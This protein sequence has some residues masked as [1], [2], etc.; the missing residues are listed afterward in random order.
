MAGEQDDDPADGCGTAAGDEMD[1]WIDG[2]PLS[3]R[4]PPGSGGTGGPRPAAAV[5][6]QRRAAVPAVG[7]SVPPAPH[8]GQRRASS[9]AATPVAGCL[10]GG[11]DDELDIPL[12]VRLG[13]LRWSSGGMARHTAASGGWSTG[14]GGGGRGG[15]SWGGRSSRGG[16]ALDGTYPPAWTPAGNSGMGLA[17]TGMGDRGFGDEAPTQSDVLLSERLAAKA[18]S[19]RGLGAPRTSEQR[20]GPQGAPAAPEGRPRGN[21]WGEPQASEQRLGPEGMPAATGSG[22]WSIG[23]PLTRAG[24][25]RGPVSEERA[26]TWAPGSAELSLGG[27]AVNPAGLGFSGAAGMSGSGHGGWVNQHEG[28][29]GW[30]AAPQPPWQQQGQQEEQPP[31]LQHQQQGWGRSI[32]GNGRP[33]PAVAGP[34]VGHANGGGFWPG[35]FSVGPS[36]HQQGNLPPQQQQQPQDNDVATIMG[37]SSSLPLQRQQWAGNASVEDRLMQQQQPQA[38][39]PMGNGGQLGQPAGISDDDSMDPDIFPDPDPDRDLSPKYEAPLPPSSCSNGDDLLELSVIPATDEGLAEAPAAGRVLMMGAGHAAAGVPDSATAAPSSLAA[40]STTLHS[41]MHPRHLAFAFNA[42]PHPLLPQRHHPQQQ[43]QCPGAMVSGNQQLQELYLAWDHAELGQQQQQPLSLHPGQGLQ[44][45]LHWC[46]RDQPGGLQQSI[47]VQRREQQVVGTLGPSAG[48]DYWLSRQQQQQRQADLSSRG[49]HANDA[50][51]PALSEL[52]PAGLPRDHLAVIKPSDLDQ[53]LGLD[54]PD[55]DLDPDARPGHVD[56]TP[57]PPSH[58][59]DV[60]DK[61]GGSGGG[62]QFHSAAAP[63][64]P[65]TGGSVVFLGFGGGAGGGGDIRPAGASSTPAASP[66]KAWPFIQRVAMGVEARG[67]QEAAGSFTSPNTLLPL[68]RYEGRSLPGI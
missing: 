34:A 63:P 4:I 54:V 3:H 44:G 67:A 49:Q 58:A 8:S 27:N 23:A 52:E 12:S 61:G 14:S 59:V 26:A 65:S 53:Y 2:L 30:R 66:S 21:L 25:E 22:G 68:K 57:P 28:A 47:S 45:G 64:P 17:G 13:R 5:A 11:G 62:F 29:G 46:E 7:L 20:F 40:A 33:A 56:G 31:R 15:R 19:Q 18:G 41:P 1:A 43:Q 6:V 38:S 50:V 36:V 10:Q 55:P 16:A 48:Q 37:H 24:E 32:S 60:G 35:A 51:P 42:S 39:D 9:V